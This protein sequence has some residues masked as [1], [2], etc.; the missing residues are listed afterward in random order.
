MGEAR[1]NNCTL[2]RGGGGERREEGGD[3]SWSSHSSVERESVCDETAKSTPFLLDS[4]AP[5]RARKSQQV[6][7]GRSGS[8]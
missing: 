3:V 5:H 6:R 1:D 2:K 7:W 4:M 8:L